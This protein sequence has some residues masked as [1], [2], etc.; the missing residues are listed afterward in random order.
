MPVQVHEHIWITLS[1]GCRLGARLWLPEAA[2]HGGVPAVLEYIPYRKRDGTRGRDDP[3][4]GYFAEQGY[5]AVRVDMRGS[6][7]SDGYLADEYLRQEQDDALEVIAWIAAQPWCSGSVGLQGKSWG[8]FNA[9]QIAARRPPALKAIITTFS[10]DNRYTDDIHYMGGCLLNDNLWWGSIM[11]AYQSRP[12]DPEVVGGQ[13]RERWL[14]RIHRLP[15][16]P[17]LWLAHQRYD[18]YWK[19]GSVCEDFAAIACPVMAIGGWTDAYTNAVPRLLAGLKVPRLGIIGP[20]GHVYPHDGVPGPAIGYL[21]E[22]V[23][24]W[25][26]WLKGTDTGIMREPMLR[27]YLEDPVPPEG[28]RTFTPGR[29]VGE[30]TFPSADIRMHSFRLRADGGLGSDAGESRI[31]DIRSPQSHGKAAGEWMGVGCP[32]EHPTDQRLDDGG[33]LVFDT[34]VLHSELAVLGAPELTLR[35]ASDVPVAQ[36]AVRLSDV[37]PDERVTRVSYQVLNLTHRDSHEQPSPLEPGRPYD[38]RVTLNACGHRFL[39][40]HRVRLCVASAYWPMVWPAPYAATLSVHTG[41]S[42]LE[43]PVRQGAEDVSVSFPP[44]AHGPRTPITVIAPGR[45]KRLST[46]DHIGGTTTYVTEGEG[47]VFGEGVLR[48]DAVDVQLSHSL[49][50]ELTIRDEDPLSARYVLTQS[51]EMGREGWRTRVETRAQMRSDARNFYLSGTLTAHLNGEPVAERAW[52]FTFA[53]DL[54]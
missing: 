5:A 26:Q 35:V 31:L 29:W 19:H 16:F 46:Q 38:I 2:V 52:D 12:L 24:W 21:Q 32:G 37:A 28:T 44:P 53:R 47:G 23:R 41:G 11:L 39:P 34:P 9:L 36:L 40:G 45:L 25:D 6:G 22:A 48:F 50:R 42:T 4:H 51:Y 10:T 8:G 43:L 27:A 13:W 15:F 20:W 49:K 18:D 7:E 3:M 1:D 33:A 30:R 54:L 14:E 17:A